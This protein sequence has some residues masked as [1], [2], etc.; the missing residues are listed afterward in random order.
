MNAT[1]A[2]LLGATIGGVLSVLAS[3]IAQRLQSKSQWVVQEIQQ[4]QRLYSEFIQAS[5]RCY[6]DALQQNDPDPGRLANLYGE[7]G[8]M[9]LYSSPRVIEEAYNVVRTILETYHDRNRDRG[10]IR[11]LLESGSVDLYSRFGEACRA[12]LSRLS[13]NEP[14]VFSRPKPIRL[15]E[16]VARS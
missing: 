16:L 10:E 8:R 15:P 12:E 7:I 6:A 2:A 13:P 9:R 4:R 5:V 3:W 11:D 14:H 1:L